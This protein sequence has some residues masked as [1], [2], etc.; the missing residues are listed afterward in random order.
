MLDTLKICPNCQQKI[1]P[2]AFICVRCGALV[3]NST[4]ASPTVITTQAAI[5]EQL[6]QFVG[7][8]HDLDPLPDGVLAL[9]PETHLTPILVQCATSIILGRQSAFLDVPVIDLSNFQAYTLGVSRQHA[10]IR[11]LPTG[12]VIEDLGS[13]NGT[14]VN[15]VLLLPGQSLLLKPHDRVALSNLVLT[16]VYTPEA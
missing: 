15:G 1:D 6:R 16:V 5:A 9:F 4:M 12:Y 14:K 3:T 11:H 2:N 7:A 10:R 13:A 8:P